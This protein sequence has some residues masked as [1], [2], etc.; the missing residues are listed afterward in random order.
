MGKK[1]TNFFTVS[2]NPTP[3][4]DYICF[5]EV[6]RVIMTSNQNTKQKTLPLPT[7]LVVGAVAGMVGTTCIFP[8]DMVKTRLMASSG[9]YTGPIHCF[10][11]IITEEG[12]FRALYRG[13][14]PNLVGVTP[15]KA[16]KLASNEY[17]REMLEE[18]DGSISLLSEVLAAAGAGT[19]QIIAT[20]PMEITKIR[21]QM[22]A[23][24]PVAERQSTIQVVKGLGIRGLYSGSLATLSRDIPYSVLF[25]PGY[26][27]LKKLLADEKGEN[28]ILSILM[29][30][31]AAGAMA[32]GA[33]TPTDV[34]KTRLQV[35]GGKEKY[36]NIPTALAKIFKEE[37]ITALYKGVVPRM[38]VIGTLFAITLLSFEAQKTYMIK[39]GLL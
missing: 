10:R 14:G 29:A 25:F 16:I 30:G 23:L 38:T 18:E 39:N 37:G 3:E 32:A 24:L 5:P 22:Q 34:I 11:S 20:N 36:K 21:M 2:K 9:R 15:E 6:L 28:S 31:G 27:N 4:H 19:I 33:V 13:L 26:A 8:I 17:F 1:S 12:G 7:K 35:A